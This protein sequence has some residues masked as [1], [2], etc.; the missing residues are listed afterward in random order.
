MLIS[1]SDNLFGGKTPYVVELAELSQNK[2]KPLK[3]RTVSSFE[4][5]KR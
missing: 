4:R 3:L 5:R 1:V 2:A